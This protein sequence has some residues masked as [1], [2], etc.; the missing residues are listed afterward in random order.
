M[1]FAGASSYA[2]AITAT[3]VVKLGDLKQYIKRG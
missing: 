3:G 1:V 2:I